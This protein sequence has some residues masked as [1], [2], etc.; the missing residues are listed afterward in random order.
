MK[1]SEATGR[2][3]YTSYARICVEMDLSGTLP[4]KLILEFFDEE[5]VQTVGY[6]HIPFKHH[7]CHENGHL[8]RDCPLSKVDNKGEHKIV[9]DTENFQKLVS[10]GKGGWK[11]SRQ[12]RSE[13]QKIN[14]NRFQVLEEKEEMRRE[15]QAMLEGP[16]EK[17]KEENY[18]ITWEICNRKETMNNETEIEMDMEMTQSETNIEDHELQEI[19]ENEHLDLEGFLL[20]GTTRGIDS[21]PEEDCNRIQQLFLCKN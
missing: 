19:L 6:E 5:W 8:F 9:K 11:G 18:I 20:Q 7:R 14:T 2:G 10:K 13:G 1:A 16:K 17:E 4:D 3:K 15:D 12:Q 21:L